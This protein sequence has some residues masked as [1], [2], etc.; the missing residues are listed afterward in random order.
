MKAFQVYQ[1]DASDGSGGGGTDTATAGSG[2]QDAAHWQAEAKKAFEARQRAKADADALAAKLKAYEG[3]DPDEYRTL[4]QQREDAEQDRA[5]KAGEFDKLKEQLV[6]KHQ[7]ELT[8][9]EKKAAD[10]EQR[11][12]QT[13]IG[14]AFAD[15]SDLFGPSGKT[16]YL[17]ADAERIFG[18]RVRL[19]DDG[20]LVVLDGTGEVMLDGKTGKPL[21]FA[22]A[23]AEYIDSLPDKQYRLRGSGKTGSGSSG[24][25]TGG[26]EDGPLDASRLTPDQLRDPKVLAKLRAQVG[27]GGQIS[28]RA[29]E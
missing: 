10:L 21:P 14:R 12:R 8:A 1:N 20:A 18:D 9:A 11:W 7:T 27:R 16:I 15:A 13:V 5:K 3:V 4:K 2:Q 22:A 28:G 17:P 19:Q 26:R 24:G 23:M 29:Y 6:T 25:M